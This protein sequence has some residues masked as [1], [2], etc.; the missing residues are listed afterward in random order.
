MAAPD[1][2]LAFVERE[3]REVPSRCCF[4]APCLPAF[5][6]PR[7]WQVLAD[8]AARQLRKKLE[9]VEREHKDLKR[10]YFQ[11]SLRQKNEK[12]GTQTDMFPLPREA[13]TALVDDNVINTHVRNEVLSKARRTA[14]ATAAAAA[15]LLRPRRQSSSSDYCTMTWE[16][17][18]VVGPVWGS[19]EAHTPNSAKGAEDARSLVCQADLE[20]HMGAV[21]T[22]KFSRKGAYLASGSFDKTVRLWAWSWDEGTVTP[23]DVVALTDHTLNVS[24]VSWGADDS[25]LVSGAYDKT[26]KCWDI[27]GS[28]AAGS[29]ELGSFVLAVACLP[30]DLNLFWAASS[31]GQVYLLDRRAPTHALMLNND[32]AMVNGLDI[33][34]C[35]ARLFTG[36][37]KGQIRCWDR[38]MNKQVL[39]QVDGARPI[40]D[41]HL[42]SCGTVAND[43]VMV[44]GSGPGS[45]VV[46]GG[47]SRAED[48]QESMAQSCNLLA[49]NCYDN[50]LRVY[51]RMGG[52]HTG[53]ASE[54]LPGAAGARGVAME[55]EDESNGGGD[56][57]ALGPMSLIESPELLRP[58][59]IFHLQGHK[60]KNFP[61][62]STYFRGAKFVNKTQVKGERGGMWFDRSLLIAT[63]SVDKACYIYDIGGPRYGEVIQKLEGHTDRVYAASFHPDRTRPLLATASADSKLKLWTPVAGA[64]ERPL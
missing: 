36:D 1:N 44:S 60:N 5:L 57:S 50:I 37:S 58:S 3:N 52:L 6:G 20:G 10:A 8:A 19:E 48:W 22:A 42:I 54:T 18:Q 53:L 7:A 2:R 9:Q 23:R 40:S 24:D 28:R 63:G 14:A 31:Q 38:G 32:G 15:V 26:V 33:S 62:R 25:F 64:R 21:Y 46:T 29:Y 56:N 11:L 47:G 16:C 30:S 51:P 41:L 27:A 35:G 34:A 39:A 4:L 12:D 13:E 17:L 49:I 61:I 55:G 59:P 43:G 45:G